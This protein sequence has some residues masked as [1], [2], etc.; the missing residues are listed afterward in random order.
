MTQAGRN[1]LIIARMLSLPPANA[2]EQRNDETSSSDG[3]AAAASA[4]FEPNE[5]LAV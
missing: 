1:A 3:G 4:I 2:A 5:D